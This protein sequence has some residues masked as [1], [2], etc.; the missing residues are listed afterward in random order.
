ME[1]EKYDVIVAGG[2]PAG[3]ISAVTAR[4]YY[5]D[6]SILL[7]KS[8][9][10]GVIPC[11]IPY[12]FNS[13]KNP[14]DNIMGSAPLEKSRV[15]IMLDEV[16]KV[17][18]KAK[19]IT[20]KAGKILGYDK[21]ILAMGS[22]PILPPIKGLDSKNVFPIYKDMDY[23]KGVKEK[24]SA[25]KNIVII[26][27]GFIGIEFADEI[28]GLKGKNVSLVEM[29]PYLLLNSFDS[30][31]G[32]MVGAKLEAKGVKLLLNSKVEEI[33]GSEVRLSD[34]T[35]IPA[36][37]VILGIGASPNTKLAE[38]AGLDLGKGKGIWVD[39]YMR[40]ADPDVFAVG[41]CV[42]KRD[43]FTRKNLPVMLASTA[44]AEARVAGANLFKLKVVRENKGTIAIYSTCLDGL[45]LGSAGLTESAARGE[46]F[47]VEVG[48]AEV[49]DKHPAAMPGANKIKLKLIFSKQSG[50]ILGGQV[51]GGISAGEI[52]NIIGM[53]IQK[54]VSATELETLQ[55]ATHPCLTAPPTMYPLVLAAQDAGDKI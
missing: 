50:I 14:E 5:P 52:I 3:V 20:T 51:S 48:R 36:D 7:I 12:M 46:G 22:N 17:S 42:G 30:E 40:T 37:M 21:L 44:T 47:E 41:D 19:N 2:G 34:G 10:K 35:T 18:R 53:A 38:E 28:S 31:F 13:L 29:F 15:D 16:T 26:G 33:L 27:G 24:L 45:A 55:M 4:K 23:L 49:P 43:F 9:G 8:V 25:A 54:R 6:K 32:E 1:K 11:G 39:E